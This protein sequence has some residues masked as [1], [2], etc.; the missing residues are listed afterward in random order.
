MIFFLDLNLPLSALQKKKL[1]KLLNLNFYKIIRVPTILN[2]EPS[3]I[4]YKF[5]SNLLNTKYKD[6]KFIK[7]L[8]KL[9]FTFIPTEYNLDFNLSRNHYIK[10][11]PKKYPKI[12]GVRS[13]NE[14]NPI[15][16]FWTAE[17]VENGTKIISCQEGG[18]DG[19]KVENLKDE[20][21]RTRLC[22]T[23]LSWGWE[24]KHNNKIKK[25]YITKDFPRNFNYNINGSIILLGASCRKYF[26][27]SS[28]GQLPS[29]N[30]TLIKYNL[31]FIKNL[32]KDSFKK[33]IYRFHWEMGFNE[34]KIIS[35]KIS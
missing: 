8:S 17:L 28:S 19:A 16:R 3:N 24:N 20:E 5:S 11:L 9:I 6:D 4:F 7:L 26:F 15:I 27:S 32:N 35:K 23:F 30:N 29:Y 22:D 33:L 14:T 18:G 10:F 21:F 13:P 1:L 34:K 2:H 25:F 31:D 12:V